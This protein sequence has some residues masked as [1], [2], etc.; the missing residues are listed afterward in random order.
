MGRLSEVRDS[1]GTLLAA[2]TYNAQGQRTRKVTSQGTTVYHYDL[3]GNLIS[4][5]Q[6]DGTPIRDYVWHNATPLAQL[7]VGLTETLTYLHADHLSTPRRATSSAG[8]VIWRWEGEAFGNTPPNEDVDGNGQATAIN[9]RFPGQYFDQE[10]GL[11]YNWNRHYDPGKGRY[12]TSDPIGTLGDSNT[13][14]YS[15]ANPLIFFDPTGLI[16][17]QEGCEINCNL[18]FTNREEQRLDNFL[19]EFQEC[20]LILRPSGVT[21]CR[22]GVIGIDVGRKFRNQRFLR[23][24]LDGCA[25]QCNPTPSCS[26][27]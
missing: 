17:C 19:R 9:L 16:P 5:T 25:K 13:Y 14:L 27:S 8:T 10:T 11:H 22:L 2:Y 24:C 18:E 12:I 4:E 1:S 23:R 3:A 7:E 6:A 26:E 15:L 21:T 20:T